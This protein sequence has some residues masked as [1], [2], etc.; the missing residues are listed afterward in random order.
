V[1][2]DPR[3][4]PHTDPGRVPGP[5]PGPDADHDLASLREDYGLGGLH[6]E[7]VHADPLVMLRQWM[8]DAIAAGLY[9]P[10]AMVLSTVSAEG[11]PS[12]RM[13]LCK[14]VEAEG[15]VFY[16]NYGSAKGR[17]LGSNGVCALLFPWHPIQ[18]QVRVEGTA[19]RLPA[20][21]SDAYFASRPRPSQL[22]AW[23][24]E[25]S[26]TVP[27]REALEAAYDEVA[28]RFDGVEVPRPDFWGGYLV[29]P[30]V[31]ELWQ[32]RPGRLHDRLRY[33]RTGD[34]WLVDRLAP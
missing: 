30:A 20:P 17:D 22:A 7:D 14:G 10:T 12:S 13:V 6:E 29:T 19:A 28:R 5:A 27:S 26:A 25:Q 2:D 3:P 15:V 8:K 33:R 18:R 31:V 1:V 24:S 32:G 9:D 11:T 23:A 21:V 16:S 4:G 34:G